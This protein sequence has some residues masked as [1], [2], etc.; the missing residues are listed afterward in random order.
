MTTPSLED[1]EAQVFAK[2]GALIEAKGN[3]EEIDEAFIAELFKG[4]PCPVDGPPPPPHTKPLPVNLTATY[5]PR[6]LQGTPLYKTELS[7]QGKVFYTTEPPPFPQPGHPGCGELT[8]V[9]EGPATYGLAASEQYRGYTLL[10]IYNETSY[11]KAFYK[12]SDYR[13]RQ[14]GTGSWANF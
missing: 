14:S 7:A 1:I 11:L 2:L 8:G 5:G 10:Q 3:P 9:P 13:A 12:D 4:I 6:G